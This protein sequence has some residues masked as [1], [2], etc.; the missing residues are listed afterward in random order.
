MIQVICTDI[1]GLT[2]SDYQV[3]YE[4]SSNERRTRAD[5]YRRRTDAFR[6]VTADGLLRYVLGTSDYTVEKTASGKPFIKGRKDF[7]YNLTHSGN[8][9][10]LA[11]GDSEIGVDVEKICADTDIETIASRFFSSEEQQYIWEE[12]AQSRCRFF[13]IWTG[14]ESYL[15][16]LGTGLRQD[17]TSFSV[18]SLNSTVQ[19]HHRK[20]DDTHC[21]SL[22]TTCDDFLLELLDVQRLL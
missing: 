21:L 15:K 1:S 17:L 14:K 13:E 19:L 16:Y 3:L 20:L 9:V 22:C 7:H 6:G 4:K 10:V 11:F 12:P 2:S 5:R 8:W 18:L